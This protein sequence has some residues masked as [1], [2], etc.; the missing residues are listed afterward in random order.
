ML[1]YVLS[2]VKQCYLFVLCK[3]KWTEYDFLGGDY[4]RKLWVCF[5]LALKKLLPLLC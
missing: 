1:F 5:E 2:G 4:P 3:A